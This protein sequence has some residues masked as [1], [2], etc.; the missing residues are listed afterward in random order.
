MTFGSSDNHIFSHTAPILHTT[1][2]I[3]S[4]YFL[5]PNMVSILKSLTNMNESDHLQFL[6]STILWDK[7]DV[8]HKPT[9]SHIQG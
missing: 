4:L 7:V 9:C 8:L 6:K 3:V 1:L 2:C 5:S